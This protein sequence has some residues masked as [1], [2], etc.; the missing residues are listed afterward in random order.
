MLVWW[1]LFCFGLSRSVPPTSFDMSWFNRDGSFR[2]DRRSPDQVSSICSVGHQTFFRWAMK[3][4]QIMYTY[5]RVF[6][7]RF[8]TWYL[9]WVWERRRMVL[10]RPNRCTSLRWSDCLWQTPQDPSGV[11]WPAKYNALSLF[12]HQRIRNKAIFEGPFW[13]EMNSRSKVALI[14]PDY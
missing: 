10:L 13:C 7:Y 11:A 14:W 1:Y 2:R 5:A 3:I 6:F 4:F 9:P 8:P 12:R